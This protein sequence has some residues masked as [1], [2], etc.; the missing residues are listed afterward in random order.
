MLIF[1]SSKKAKDS[2]HTKAQRTQRKTI[3][4]EINRENRTQ[5]NTDYHDAKNKDLTEKIIKIFYK[6]Y[7]N[8]GYGFLEKVYKNA[9][10]IEFKQTGIPVVSQS[11]I[12]VEYES[13][14]IGE[15]FADILVDNKVIVEIKA[16]KSLAVEYEAQLLNYLKA[17]DI[18]VGLLLNF[19]PK[20]DIK[21]KVLDNIRK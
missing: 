1:L 13:E 5:M 21:R 9:M 14:V 6:V 12:K 7:N 10:M 19:D 2:P 18:E 11:A 15:Y 3:M 8:L 20:P 4:Q 16:A 17:T